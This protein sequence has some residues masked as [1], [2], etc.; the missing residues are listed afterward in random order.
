MCSYSSATWKNG[1]FQFRHSCGGLSDSKRR[2]RKSRSR[3]SHLTRVTI[4]GVCLQIIYSPYSFAERDKLNRAI[5]A[6]GGTGTK[7]RGRPRKTPA[8][9]TGAAVASAPVPTKKHH[10]R[11]PAARKAQAQRM[12]A[13]WAAKAEEAGRE[14]G[15]SPHNLAF[16]R[17]IIKVRRNCNWNLQRLDRRAA[18]TL[19][20]EENWWV[21]SLFKYP[22]K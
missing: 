18:L 14:V 15:A 1:P 6:L 17:L 5:E 10:M 22:T 20:Y 13:Y 12:K 9:E 8:G 16:Y 3:V 19:G 7:R 4:L 11:S 21:G 2:L